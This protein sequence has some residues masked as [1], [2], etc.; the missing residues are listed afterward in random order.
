[1]QGFF[2][3]F[4]PPFPF[5]VANLTRFT[6]NLTPQWVRINSEERW[7]LW[8]REIS[9]HLHKT[10]SERICYGRVKYEDATENELKTKMTV[11]CLKEYKK[12][13]L[14]LTMDTFVFSSKIH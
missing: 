5:P 11:L 14:I 4:F 12:L 13:S 8:W 6:V 2:F 7:N 10:A 1:M 9:P 3:L